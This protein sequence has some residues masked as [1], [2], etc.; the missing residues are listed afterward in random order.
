[1][2]KD[3]DPSR[4]SVTLARAG[5][6]VS[7]I[8]LAA[9]IPLTWSSWINLWSLKPN[10][11]G[12]LM[13]GTF[14]PLAFL[15]L[16]LGFFQQGQELRAS[17]KALE[18]QGEELRNSVEQQRQLVEVTKSEVELNAK[19]LK[20]EDDEIARSSLPIIRLRTSMVRQDE[21]APYYIQFLDFSNSG[22]PASD[23]WLWID[24]ERKRRL[25]PILEQGGSG[26]FTHRFPKEGKAT[27]HVKLGFIDVRNLQRFQEWR[28]TSEEG[29]CEVEE[30]SSPHFG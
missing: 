18:L 16:V 27:L 7:V 11:F 25:F 8:Y 10:E 20:Q 29:K 28:V 21:S 26:E 30:I 15:W 3:E 6:F 2:A 12:D 19:R 23:V 9:L 24:G 14:A 13:A 17:V 1:M 5:F 4:R 22:R